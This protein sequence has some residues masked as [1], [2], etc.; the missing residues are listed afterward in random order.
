L[1]RR[2][3]PTD[4]LQD[5]CRYLGQALAEQGYD[6]ELVR[7]PW[8]E[9][10]WLPALNW[11]RHQSK[12]WKGCWV[13]VQYTALGWSRR[14]IPLSLLGVLGL[15]KINGVRVAIVFHDPGP[16]SGRRFVDRVRRVCQRCLMHCS[17]WLTDKSILTIPVED[18]SWLPSNSTKASFIPV[19]ANIPVVVTGRSASGGYQVK[20]IAVFGV[21]GDGEVGSEVS[22]IA[23]A[24]KAAAKQL[25]G[26]RLVTIGR[27]SLESKSKFQVAL[28]GS[29]VEHLA[30]GILAAED[31]SRVLSNADVSL[32]VRGCISTQK[33]SALASIACGLPLVAYAGTELASS[34]S[35]AGVV[36]VPFG[37]REQLAQATIDVLTD[38]RLWLDLHRRSQDSYEKYFAWDA[39]AKS[40]VK[41][42]YNA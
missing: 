29:R 24:A 36:P 12:R 27:G 31:V 7:M 26:I 25:H 9:R 22:D 1:G 40:F 17:Y 18:A 38:N 15:L 2:D 37:D 30:L 20:T 14:G 8:P 6:L 23:F 41:V 42:F 11:L 33:G 13:L 16:Y 21:T 4:A 10:G 32:F 34:I 5:Y 28:R 19:G 35:E 3:H 39:V